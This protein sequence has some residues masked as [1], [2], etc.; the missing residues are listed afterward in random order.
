[1]S[2]AEKPRFTSEKWCPEGVSNP[3]AACD[4]AADFKY[5]A[6]PSHILL[7][8]EEIHAKPA[9]SAVSAPVM[10]KNSPTFWPV[11]LVL[12]VV[13]LGLI[14][15]I[16]QLGWS[17]ALREHEM[18][19]RPDASTADKPVPKRND[20]GGYEWPGGQITDDVDGKQPVTGRKA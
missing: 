14:W 6:Q 19:T 17:L 2:E 1:M 5:S 13:T 16:R 7:T 18:M 15:M 4:A 12:V 9:V 10:A 3:H 8:R 20:G 11:G